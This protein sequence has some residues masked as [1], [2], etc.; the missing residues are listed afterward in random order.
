MFT[1][2]DSW[3]PK[4]GEKF[5]FNSKVEKGQIIEHFMM[6][7]EHL[8]CNCKKAP[9]MEEEIEYVASKLWEEIQKATEIIDVWSPYKDSFLD[10][11]T[12]SPKILVDFITSIF[13]VN[14]KILERKKTL[15]NS[16]YQEIN[17]IYQDLMYS[18]SNGTIR[19]KKHAY[20]GLCL[21]CITSSKE[22]LQ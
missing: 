22:C 17:S 6:E 21:K 7:I 15:I 3:T 2:I 9:T 1:D 10:Y 5:F 18:F 14:S 4:Y 19:T 8:K 12:E 11:H 16:I 20:L 13:H